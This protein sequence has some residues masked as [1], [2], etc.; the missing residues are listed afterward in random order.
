MGWGG[1]RRGNGTFEL[2]DGFFDETSWVGF[3]RLITRSRWGLTSV[4]KRVRGER[5]SGYS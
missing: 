2:G 3:S 1:T 4:W 5:V